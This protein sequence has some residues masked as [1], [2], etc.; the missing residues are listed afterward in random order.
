MYLLTLVAR[1]TKDNPDHGA[2]GEAYINCWV[3]T[4]NEADA[5]K[6]ANEAAIAD[7]WRVTET[8]EIS[9]LTAET[10]QEEDVQYYEQALTDNTVLVCHLCPRYPVYF[11]KLQVADDSGKCE[12]RVWILNEIVSDQ[13]DPF[14]PDFWTG[15][16]L[17]RALSIATETLK[18]N[19]LK[20][21][22]VVDQF[23]C[24]SDEAG[25]EVKFYDEAESE[26]LCVVVVHE[27]DD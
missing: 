26:G 7:H 6:L 27:G 3:N 11:F 1:T 12:A 14:E 17:E 18:D 10:C 13:H 20:V 5:I 9:V 8:D 15:Q 22:K 4:D 16:R 19:G 23:P 2:I 24:G 21:L 25:D